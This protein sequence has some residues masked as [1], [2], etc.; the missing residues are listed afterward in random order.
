MQLTFEFS[1]AAATAIAMIGNST[2][3]NWLTYHDRRLSGW[4]FVRSLLSF[5]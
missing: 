4:Q 2:L 3:N 1:Q 5:A